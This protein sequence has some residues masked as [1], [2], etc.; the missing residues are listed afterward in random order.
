MA[1]VV[2]EI[3]A[4]LAEGLLSTHVPRTAVTKRAKSVTATVKT[5]TAARR[6]KPDKSPVWPPG[7]ATQLLHI[8][9][10]ENRGE[11]RI[12]TSPPKPA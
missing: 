10:P 7:P 6:A 1:G 9:S 4:P 11:V 5:E 3:D 12:C 2:G 8:H